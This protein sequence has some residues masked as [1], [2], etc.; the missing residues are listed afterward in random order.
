MFIGII[1]VE[2]LCLA[3]LGLM[4]LQLVQWE[5]WLENNRSQLLLKIREQSSRLKS[6]RRQVEDTGHGVPGLELSPANRRKVQLARWI[7]RS[8]VAAKRAR[9]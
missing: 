6:I 8:L 2:F 9:S 7:G 3:I 1:L 4:L 5:A